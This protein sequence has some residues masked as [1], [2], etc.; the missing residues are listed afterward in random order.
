MSDYQAIYD[1]TLSAFRHV[2]IAGPIANKVAFEFGSAALT[3]QQ[4]AQSAMYAADEM[5]RPSVQFRPRIFI[6][7]DQWCAL[8]G[9]NVQ[10]GVAGF[11]T[12]PDAAMR[13]FD[14]AWAAALPAA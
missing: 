14:A 11:G 1:A 3:A 7:G 8:Y 9:E 6:D 4:A 5:M 12:S 2:D 10:D 13:A